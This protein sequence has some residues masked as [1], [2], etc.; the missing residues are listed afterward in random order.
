LNRRL[1]K[2]ISI[3]MI[4]GLIGTATILATPDSSAVFAKSVYQV[5]NG[6]LVSAKTGKIVRGY[7]VYK[8]IL[9]KNGK[10]YTG[11]YKNYRYKSGKKLTGSYNGYLYKNGTK[12]TGT[13]NGYLYK[14]GKKLTGAYNGYQ[15]KSGKK[16][17]G[18]KDGIT[19]QDGKVVSA[20]NVEKVSNTAIVY[21]QDTHL[22]NRLNEIM[23]HKNLTQNMKV[24]DLRN[25]KGTLSLDGD[26]DE[27]EMFGMFDIEN[28]QPLAFCTNISE[29]SI[30]NNAIHNLSP[31][32][33]LTNLKN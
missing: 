13:Y 25:L 5:K 31:L 33:K 14:N 22:L 30:A 3:T 21:V 1:N 7:K 19:Y 10:K 6:K 9:Y 26:T 27:R 32:V 28:I 15:Y 20:Q 18:T 4:T 8:S 29:L 17:T 16:L 12:L 2:A 24:A 11:S 23:G